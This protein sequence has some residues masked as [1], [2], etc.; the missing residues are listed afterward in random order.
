MLPN[1]PGSG[2][3]RASQNLRELTIETLQYDVFIEKP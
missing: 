2:F 3:Q 1:D